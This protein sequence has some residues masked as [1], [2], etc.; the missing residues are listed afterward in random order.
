MM[1]EEINSYNPK[2]IRV[3]KLN[4]FMGFLYKKESYYKYYTYNMVSIGDGA[5][6]S[7]KI[8][9]LICRGK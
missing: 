4:I 1:I 8:L 9:N 5:F 7:F 2:F 6:E 3:N